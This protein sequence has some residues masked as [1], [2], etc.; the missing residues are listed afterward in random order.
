MEDY[1][2]YSYQPY[3][4]GEI[5]YNDEVRIAIQDLE[6][7]PAPCNSYLYIEGKLTKDGR[8]T[9]VYKQCYSLFISRNPI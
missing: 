5:N 3:T 6:A 2:F 7:N 4:S 8:K 1:Q 9:R